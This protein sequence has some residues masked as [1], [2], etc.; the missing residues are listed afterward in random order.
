MSN[1]PEAGRRASVSRPLH[2]TTRASLAEMPC[3]FIMHGK[4]LNGAAS[5]IFERRSEEE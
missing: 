5:K 2:S 1:F 3:M 4:M